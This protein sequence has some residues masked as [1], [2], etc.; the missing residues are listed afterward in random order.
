MTISTEDWENILSPSLAAI[1]GRM[2]EIDYFEAKMKASE[3]TGSVRAASELKDWKSQSMDDRIQ[4]MLNTKRV[5][6]DIV[7]YLTTTKN[8]FFNSVLVVVRNPEIFEFESLGEL[9]AHLPAAVRVPAEDLGVLT[10][11]GGELIVLDGQHRMAALRMVVQGVDDQGRKVTGPYSGSVDSD[12]ISVIFIK[13]DIQT[14]REIFYSINKTAK[15][16]S[17]T[18]TIVISE[19]DGL[20]ITTR[21]LMNADQPLGISDPSSGELSIVNWEKS[22]LLVTDPQLTLITSVYDTVKSILSASDFKFVNASGTSRPPDAQIVDATKLAG[23]WWAT[24]LDQCSGFSK[25]IGDKKAIKEARSDRTDPRHL[26]TRPIAHQV[27][28]RAL[29]RVRERDG[30]IL[31]AA[32]ILDRIDWRASVLDATNPLWR[33]L[34][35]SRTGRLITK[36]GNL[37]ISADLLCYLLAPELW[38]DE[39]LDV[40]ESRIAG[41]RA[42]ISAR[43][44]PRADPA[45][46][47]SLPAIS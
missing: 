4:R 38:S 9:V 6:D 21:A 29:A 10:V 8:R 19:T 2:G 37:E 27:I 47:Y 31:E 7:P 20:A 24:F 13:T 43:D 26:L 28:F 46:R 42:E 34:L 25:M 33:D 18:D 45:L 30:E 32:A 16:V 23:S 41:F 39:E 36:A 40:L 15:N 11:H 14:T 12:E 35:V 17:S 22:S 5:R 44:N 1:R 3:L